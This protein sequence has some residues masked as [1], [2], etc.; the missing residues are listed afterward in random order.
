M[1]WSHPLNRGLV[2][3]WLPLV[4]NA[5]GATLFDIAGRAHQTLDGPTW[6]A[7]PAGPRAALSFDGS[8]DFGSYTPP[9]TVSEFTVALRIMPLTFTNDDSTFWW[10][11]F[12]TSPRNCVGFT[13]QSDVG[14]LGS[15]WE[16]RVDGTGNT[17][18]GPQLSENTWYSACLSR[19]GT[20][21]QGY[22]DGTAFTAITVGS[23]SFAPENGRIG[24]HYFSGANNQH[25]NA[26]IS[27]YRIWD[28]ALTAEEWREYRIQS[29][30]GLPDL[31]ARYTPTTWTFGASSTPLRRRKMTGGVM[32]LSGG[33]S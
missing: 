19:S 3:W 7:D 30:C 31:L 8:N 21:A 17:E 28:R 29:A 5:G 6:V 16:C 13:P 24:C 20:T 9:A 12:P 33:M 15:F 1:N 23:A 22:V 10:E 32:A 25:V 18:K 2:A 4:N 26:V 11:N 14:G 27:D